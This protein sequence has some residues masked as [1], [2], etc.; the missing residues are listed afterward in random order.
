MAVT[1][2]SNLSYYRG[3]SLVELGQIAEAQAVFADL[4]AYAERELQTSAKI[5]YFA[6]SLPLLLV[7]GDDLNETR[8][9]EMEHLIALAEQGFSEL[10]CKEEGV[11]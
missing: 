4:K 7:F 10:R 6:T 3:L 9:H 2:H 8:R 1:E 11:L 5:D